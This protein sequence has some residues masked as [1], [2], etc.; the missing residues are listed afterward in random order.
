VHL[1]ADGGAENTTVLVREL[2]HREPGAVGVDIV[3]ASEVGN[4]A[5]RAGHELQARASGWLIVDEE[6][7]EQAEARNES[8]NHGADGP[9]VGEE[10]IFCLLG[11]EQRVRGDVVGVHVV[12]DLGHNDRRRDGRRQVC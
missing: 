4:R 2:L 9:F 12:S 3:N 6:V 11:L 5:S 1:A 8:E 7:V 10:D